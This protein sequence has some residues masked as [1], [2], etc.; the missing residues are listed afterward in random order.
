LKTI[1][2]KTTINCSSCVATVTPVL[3]M[4]DNVDEWQVDTSTDDKILTV[5]L[6]DS[7][8]QSVIKALKEAGYKAE[9]I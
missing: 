7:D 2:L 3:N 8:I 1:K 6:D 9:P 5:E 4:L